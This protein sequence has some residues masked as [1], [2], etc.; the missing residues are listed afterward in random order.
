MAKIVVRENVGKFGWKDKIGYALGDFGCNLSFVMQS[1]FFMV[2]YVTCLGIQPAH[3][4]LLILL[5]KIWDGVNDPLVGSLTDKI[6]PKN[7][8]EKFKPWIF[9]GSIMLSAVTMLM[10]MPIHNASY[11][12]RLLA[13]ICSY[14][15]WDMCYTIVNVPYGSMSSVMTAN[16]LERADLSKY[17]SL[18]SLL[19][20]VPA[21]VILPL[22]LYNQQTGDPIQSRFLWTA[23]V[24]GMFSFVCLQGTVRLCSERVM[25][26]EEEN[27]NKEDK[28]HFFRTFLK[29]LKSRPMVG[30]ILASMACLMFL[31]SNNTTNQYVFMLYYQDTTW[32]SV[33]MLLSYTAQ[34]LTM[35]LIRPLLKRFD[36]KTLCS[37]PFIAV[38]AITIGMIVMPMENP[39]SWV[40]CQFVI[41][42]LQGA[43]VMLVWAL[44][45]DCIDYMEVLTGRREEGSVYSSVTLFRKIGSGVGTALLGVALEMTG[46]DQNLDVAMQAANVGINVKNLAAIYL[47]AGAVIIFITMT[48]VYNL[49]NKKMKE[50]EEKLGRADRNERLEAALESGSLGGG[51]D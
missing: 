1:S 49:D 6:R 45:S 12:V 28:A 15:M 8:K 10:F 19:G 14:V 29:C 2:Y 3:F 37:I 36:R 42:L 40:V 21:G 25:H 41:G 30:L 38:I 33:T 18:G 46:Y 39:L 48:F 44:I 50:I 43:F 23:V 20:N 22:I 51:E 9:Y 32:I 4:G 24:M 16:D 17:R 7:G 47:L 11:G 13:C 35:V 27:E 26:V 31:Q 34:I 5:S